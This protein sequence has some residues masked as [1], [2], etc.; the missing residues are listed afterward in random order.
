MCILVQR[1]WQI[2]PLS[3]IHVPI[4][5]PTM[6]SKSEPSSISTLLVHIHRTKLIISSKVEVPGGFPVQQEAVGREIEDG[7]HLPT[8]DHL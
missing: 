6:L 1:G 3:Y 5:E 2:T 7:M 8:T 4:R